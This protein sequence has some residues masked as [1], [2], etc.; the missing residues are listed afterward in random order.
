MNSLVFLRGKKNP[1]DTKGHY[2]IN[3][4]TQSG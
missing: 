3:K 2:G 1:L 4:V